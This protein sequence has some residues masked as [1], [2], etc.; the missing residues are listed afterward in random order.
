MRP[1]INEERRLLR[2]ALGF[3]QSK[4]AYR[5]RYSSLGRHEAWEALVACGA[6][7]RDSHN[8][9]EMWWYWVTEAGYYAVREPHEQRAG[10]TT[11]DRVN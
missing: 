9:G 3:D 4:I 2:H 1:L 5:N 10:D 7:N 6:A 11:F 8:G